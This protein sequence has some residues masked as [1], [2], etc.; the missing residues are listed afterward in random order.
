LRINEDEEI[1]AYIVEVEEIFFFFLS[2]I[3]AIPNVFRKN[4]AT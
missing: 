4:V 1:A 2:I 3:S